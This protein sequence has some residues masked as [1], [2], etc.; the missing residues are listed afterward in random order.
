MVRLYLAAILAALVTLNLVL[1]QA[2]LALGAVYGIAGVV[3][4]LVYRHD[5]RAAAD[6]AWR[7]PE[8]V[9]LAIDLVG[10]TIGGLVAR[11][12][13]RH[14]TRKQPFS[15]IDTAIGVGHALVMATL[16]IGLWRLPQFG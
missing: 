7:V 2:P 16:L 14:K 9:L 3:S 6:G 1:G 11:E 15:A 8:A 13:L 10:G 12:A 4:F 5:K